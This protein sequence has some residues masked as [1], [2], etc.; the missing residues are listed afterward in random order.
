[1]AMWPPGRT[2]RTASSI[3][4]RRAAL[5]GRL[6]NREAADD[7]I[8]GRIGKL[9]IGHVAGVQFDPLGDTF[10][11]RIGQCRLHGIAGLVRPP[12]VHPH[13][14]SPRHQL[15]GGQQDRAASATQVEHSFVA[16]QAHP[17]QQAC[18]DFK[19]SPA[20]EPQNAGTGADQHDG[21]DG[22]SDSR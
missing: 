9:Q 12:D 5:P 14:A 16:A 18:P 15:R 22:R 10:G 6:W 21:N 19:L 7:E 13:S 20:A 8:E 17:G 4:A 1:M 3:A 2:T 11:V